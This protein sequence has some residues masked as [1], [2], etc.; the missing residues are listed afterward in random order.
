MNRVMSSTLMVTM[1][2]SFALAGGD[3]TEAMEPVVNIPQKEVVI[4]DDN[5]KYDGFYAG[6]AL[7]NVRM[8]EAVTASGT[9]LTLAGG[10]YFNKYIGVEARYMRT[11]SD[12]D[13]DS[14]AVVVT[15]DDLLSNAGI[16]VKPMYSLTTGFAFYGLA[17][18][19]KST[20]EKSGTEH[21]E[22][23]AQWGLGAKYELSN[24]VGIFADYLDIHSDDNYDGIILDE[25]SYD[26]MNFGA[27]YSF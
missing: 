14:G 20:Y 4:L 3:F 6:A 2:A 17:G 1:S 10:Y 8:N 16:Y 18:Y 22:S 23:G 27:T 7:G 12:L 25:V 24:G 5:V 26:S 21:T 19:G 9:M 13:V 11:I 15:Q